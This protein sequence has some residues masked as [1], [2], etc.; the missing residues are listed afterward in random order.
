[1]EW[2]GVGILLCVGWYI[3]P[4]VIVAVIGTIGAI[5]MFLFGGRK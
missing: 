4:V 3:A 1:M 2:I 5:G